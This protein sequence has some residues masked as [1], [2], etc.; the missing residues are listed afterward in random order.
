MQSSEHAVAED[1]FDVVGGVPAGELA[2]ENVTLAVFVSGSASS[3][4]EQ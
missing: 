4:D 2:A 1:G 3:S